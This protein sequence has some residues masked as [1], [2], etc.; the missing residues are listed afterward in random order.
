MEIRSAQSV[1]I[2]INT[3]E[4]IYGFGEADP[5]WGITG[6]TQSINLAV[7]SDLARLLLDKD[8]LNI[9]ERMREIDKFLIHNST[10]R[11]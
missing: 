11:R 9:E 6:E 4:G 10:L 7:A 5:T 8:P 2:K 3:N 1:F